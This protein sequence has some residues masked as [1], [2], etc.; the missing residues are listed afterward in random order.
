MCKLPPRV[1]RPSDSAVPVVLWLC[2][3]A[4]VHYATYR[5]ADAVAT[6]G[7]DGMDLRGFVSSVRSGF[8]RSDVLEVTFEAVK[9]EPQ[10]PDEARSIPEQA[11][12]DPNQSAP[13][14]DPD[15][16]AP[17]PDRDKKPDKADKPRTD[18]TKKDEPKEPPKL[19]LPKIKLDPPPP[20][21]KPLPAEEKKPEPAPPPPVERPKATAVEQ[22]VEDEHQKPNPTADKIAD[23]DNH[24]KEETRAAITNNRVNDKETSPGAAKSGDDTVK[25]PGNADKS[26]IADTEDKAGTNRAPGDAAREAR[27]GE[28]RS[29][30]KDSDKA[31]A[32]HADRA[33]TKEGEGGKA[34][35]KGPLTD[36]RAPEAPKPTEERAPPKGADVVAGGDKGTY[37]VNPFARDTKTI[38]SASAANSAEPPLA[39]RTAPYS[40]PRLGGGPGPNGVNFNLS[41]G[42]ALAVFGERALKRERELDGERRR[43]AHRGKWRPSGLDRI[44]QQ[45]ENYVAHV[46][47]GDTNAL[48]TASVPF[49]RYLARIHN[50]LHPIF[51]DEFLASL[52]ALPSDHPANNQKIRTVLELV[53]DKDSGKILESG[54]VRTS[55]VTM[56]DLAALDAMD[57]AA[58]FG[59]PPDAILSPDGRVY[60]HWEFHRAPEIACTTHYAYPFILKDAP[61]RPE[62]QK[63]LPGPRVPLEPRER[64]VPAPSREGRN[65]TPI[66]AVPSRG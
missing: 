51:A 7:L 42:G 28:S 15:P 60:L 57:R 50:Q 29:A 1:S 38:G 40:L 36:A 62:K 2:A 27:A 8:E 32:K 39:K 65:D 43:S 6:L 12:P 13:L 47:L 22:H 33:S 14:R 30:A 31:D 11:A 53:L 41:P 17:K 45:I 59:K 66:P 23:H 55:G 44:K 63:P 10:K 9:D 19:E 64:G 3:A 34:G 49:A 16:T 52:E 26:R 54:V 24:V 20:T 35:P 4:V 46:K 37:S 5:S 18:P 56:F 21:P 48:N 25:E 61:T 58:P